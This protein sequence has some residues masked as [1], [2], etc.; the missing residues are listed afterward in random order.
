MPETNSLTVAD[1]VRVAIT[2]GIVTAFF[3]QAVEWF[4]D[5][6]KVSRQLRRDATYLTLRNAIVLEAFALQCA[7][8]LSEIEL[9]NS[10][11]GHAL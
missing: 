1:I 7:Y 9:H 8:D 4:R 3:N 2:A 5:T 6:R 11:G 10:S